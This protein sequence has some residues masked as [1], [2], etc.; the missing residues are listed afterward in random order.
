M[1]SLS[2]KRDKFL[3]LINVIV[4]VN[5]GIFFDL[6]GILKPAVEFL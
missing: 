3:L 4:N 1:F 2:Y 5:A 6:V